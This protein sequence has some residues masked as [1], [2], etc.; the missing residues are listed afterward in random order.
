MRTR[1]AQGATGSPGASVHRLIKQARPARAR[2]PAPLRL[3]GSLLGAG[4]ALIAAALIAAACLG[5]TT[6]AA[7][8]P[9]GTGRSH[10]SPS[11]VAAEPVLAA[12]A[13]VLL[14]ARSLTAWRAAHPV[15]APKPAS[16]P[17]PSPP[18]VLTDSNS[19]T[20]P[21]WACIR[22]HESG[23]RF[24]TPAV[25]GGAYGFLEMT[26][27]SLGYSGWPYQAS[28]S[29]QSQ[30]ALYLYNE[31]GWQPWSTRFVCGL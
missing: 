31:L 13:H 10:G 25:P 28:P 16:P 26:W 11:L 29:V 9:S 18:P 14:R 2:G 6:P 1:I 5:A 23:D 15:A 22:V 4:V 17:P 24:N 30:A 3:V 7:G 19:T 20:T 21:D 12:R 27:L 8:Q